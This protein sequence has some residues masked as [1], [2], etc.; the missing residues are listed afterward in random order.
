MRSEIKSPERSIN[1]FVSFFFPAVP[2]ERVQ[3]REALLVNLNKRIITLGISVW[4]FN[5]AELIIE[6]KERETRISR[7]SAIVKAFFSVNSW[8]IF[9]TE[10]STLH[11]VGRL[12]SCRTKSQQKFMRSSIRIAASRIKMQISSNFSSESSVNEFL[13][14]Q[15]L[16]L[17]LWAN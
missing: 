10:P 13:S 1:I 17:R 3:T 15:S 11:R 16:R 14:F 7:F 4:K 9:F 8:D 5:S 6:L 2:R 12:A